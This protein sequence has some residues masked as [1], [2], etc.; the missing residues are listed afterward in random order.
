MGNI[1]SH[2]GTTIANT[3]NSLTK[4]FWMKE[5]IQ[6]T[7]SLKINFLVLHVQNGNVWM[8]TI[9]MKWEYRTGVESTFEISYL[10]CIWSEKIKKKKKKTNFKIRLKSP[11]SVKLVSRLLISRQVVLNWC[12]NHLLWCIYFPL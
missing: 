3:S 1:Y 11:S 4:Y 7:W 6:T 10:H 2:S 12:E 5:W 9:R 8:C